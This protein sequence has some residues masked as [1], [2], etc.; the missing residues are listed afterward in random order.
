M[1]RPRFN[2]L[3]LERKPASPSDTYCDGFAAST[4]SAIASDGDSVIE[5]GGENEATIPLG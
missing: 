4:F 1:L 5:T 2:P 3:D